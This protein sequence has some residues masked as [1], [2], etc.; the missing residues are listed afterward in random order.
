MTDSMVRIRSDRTHQRI[1]TTGRLY[2]DS[3]RRRLND[4]TLDRVRMSI[5]IAERFGRAIQPVKFEDPFLAL[6]H[7]TARPDR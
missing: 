4:S 7:C 5:A 3:S 6:A 2:R 1:K